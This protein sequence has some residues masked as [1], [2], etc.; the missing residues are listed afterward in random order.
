MS[1]DVHIEEFHGE[2]ARAHWPDVRPL[3]MLVFAV[4]DADAW[5]R[6]VAFHPGLHVLV[7]RA[8]EQVVGFKI[9]YLSRPDRMES[10]LG[11]VHPDWRRHGVGAAMM[12]RQHAWAAAQGLRRIWTLT[13]DHWPAMI[14]LNLAHGFH[15]IGSYTE[16][17]GGTKLILEKCFVRGE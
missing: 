15:I 9:G 3:A 2:E 11:G 10:W 4:D 12:R 14:A 16:R 13:H 8:A 1:P 5:D 17:S 7:A 6:R